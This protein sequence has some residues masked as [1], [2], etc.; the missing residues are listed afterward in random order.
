[1]VGRAF[2]VQ[3]AK[4]DWCKPVEAIDHASRRHPGGHRR[5]RHRGVRRAGGL[6][7]SG[8]WWA[9]S[10]TAPS[11]TW[12]A[13][14]PWSSRPSRHIAPNA[15]EGLRRLWARIIWAS[16]R[17]A[18]GT[19]S[20]AT[21][22]GGG[23]STGKGSGDR[24]PRGGRCRGGRERILRRWR[25]ERAV[26]GAGAGEVGAGPLIN[27]H[28]HTTYSDGD[29]TIE[30]VKSRRPKAAACRMWPS[31]IT[32]R[33]PR[34]TTCCRR[35][36]I[37]ISTRYAKRH[38]GIPA[39]AFW[40]GWRSIPTG[41]GATSSGCRSTSSTAWTSCCSGTSTMMA[42][43]S[44]RWSPLLSQL[45]L[46]YSPHGHRA[47]LLRPGPRRGGVEVPRLRHVRRDEQRV[48]VPPPACRS[49][50]W[51]PKY[52]T[53][54][55]A[56]VSASPSALGFPFARGRRPSRAPCR[57]AQSIDLM[58]DLLFARGEIERRV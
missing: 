29:F 24:Q 5:Q 38:N 13:S 21:T 22:G 8:E 37:S 54:R 25:G 2:T 35:S 1:M 9:W 43:R 33:P 16:S 55:S 45:R 39:C 56:S 52:F 57:F 27:L 31:P 20:S 19:G 15:G 34:C 12:T 3:T 7:R 46:R 11:A 49:T 51:R 53:R 50:S 17:C 10:S 58:D 18:P 32:S 47:H 4:G 36:S 41:H 28:N 42:R 26:H 30:Q 40:P 23:R 14:T 6:G 44:S 48:A